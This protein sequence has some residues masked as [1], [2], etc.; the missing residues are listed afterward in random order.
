MTAVADAAALELG[1]ALGDRAPD[2]GHASRLL[3]AL[4][5]PLVRTALA[6]AVIIGLGLVILYASTGA[7]YGQDIDVYR[8]G[9]VAALHHHRLYGPSFVTPTKLK[10][11]Y[12]PFAAVAFIPLGLV[13]SAAAK[14][15][16]TFCT[17]IG[18]GALSVIS[19]TA[20]F[21]T[22]IPRR[23]LPHAV[24]FSGLLALNLAPIADCLR[25]GQVG[26]FLALLC[27]ADVA[28]P[29]TRWK[30]GLLVG[31]ATA[32]KMT[33][34][35]F[36]VYFAITRDWKAVR[37]SVITLAV[38]W[39]SSVL[40]FPRDAYEYFIRGVGYDAT[41]VGHVADHLN[42]SLNGFWHR[43][44]IPAPTA[45]WLGSAGVVAAFGFWRAYRAH[46]A[47]DAVAATVIVGLMADLVAPISWL[48]H[49]AWVIPAIAVLARE[50]RMRLRAAALLIV[51]VA[52]LLM[53][54]PAIAT[55]NVHAKDPLVETYVV[56]FLALLALLPIRA[57]RRPDGPGVPAP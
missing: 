14:I 18:A 20:A 54:V 30:R 37:T 11:T 8:L 41:R 38:C 34:G 42:E 57:L 12:P 52:L 17:L 50:A 28:L 16:W 1:P 36:I 22:R 9:G 13:G 2:E 3:H 40:A 4:D 24:V 33:P 47:H 7:W 15:I 19:V 35:V 53:P 43:T 6:G 23:W 55:L 49:A 31:I 48:H 21:G 45:V 56:L 25:N 51:T 29:N 27:V 44:P 32:I 5:A 10:F 46:R 39:G 26:V